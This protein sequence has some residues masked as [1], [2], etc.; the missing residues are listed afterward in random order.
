LWALDEVLDAGHEYDSSIFPIGRP[1]Y[2]I[3]D[4]ARVPHVLAAPSGRPIVELPLTVASFLGRAVPVSGGG[5][6]RIFPF[7]VTRWGFSKANGEGRPAVF[8]MHPWEI[9]PEQPDLRSRTGALGAM[10]HYS[11]L[12]GAASKLDRLL[13]AFSF[14]SAREVLA[15]QGLLG[16]A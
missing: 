4:A 5:Y 14:G 10:R 13:Q 16:P 2:G 8:Y 6:F 12:R 7:A 1:D 9:D 15:A 3:P 11:G